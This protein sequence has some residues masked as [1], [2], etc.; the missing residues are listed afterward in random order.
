MRDKSKMSPCVALDRMI[1]RGHRHTVTSSYRCLRLSQGA[2]QSHR[3]YNLCRQICSSV[4]FPGTGLVPCPALNNTIVDVIGLR[5]REQML[6]TD[7]GAVVAFVQDEQAVRN[8][9]A[10]QFPCNPMGTLELTASHLHAAIPAIRTDNPRP[11]PARPKFRPNNG[12]VLVNIPPET[13]RQWN[14][15]CHT[16]RIAPMRSVNEDGRKGRG[17]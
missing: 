3:H 2:R 12:S 7:T 14:R 11:F 9:S 6:R 10:L 4:A 17:R 1:G 13:N 15:R 16:A 8:C 5:S